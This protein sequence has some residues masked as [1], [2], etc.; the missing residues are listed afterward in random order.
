MHQPDVRPQVA[1]TSGGPLDLGPF[2]RTSTPKP[3]PPKRT[4]RTVGN[5]YKDAAL[6]RERDAVASAPEGTRHET[7][8]RASYALARPVL[9]LCIDEVRAALLPVYHD[10]RDGEALIQGAFQKRGRQ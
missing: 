1:V 9:G 4:S 10:P 3:A 2:L 7:M 8:M 5:G 6:K